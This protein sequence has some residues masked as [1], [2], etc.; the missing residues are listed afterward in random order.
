MTNTLVRVLLV[1]DDE[2]DYVITRGLLAESQR[3]SFELERVATYHE[4]LKEIRH[5]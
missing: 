4:A 5:N 3:T 1:E 2:D